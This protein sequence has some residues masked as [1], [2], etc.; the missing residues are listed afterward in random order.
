YLRCGN[1][2]SMFFRRALF[3]EIG[4]FDV[5]L[6]VGSSTGLHSGEEADML[7]RALDAGFAPHYTPDLCV[8]HDQVDAMIGEAEVGR[9]G[10]YGRGFGALM[11]KHRFSVLEV[12]YR[13]GRSLVAAALYLLRGRSMAARYKWEWAKGILAGYRN[14]P[15]LEP[16]LLPP[17]GA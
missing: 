13:I 1:S 6:G 7:L 2:N 17:Q 14:W 12:A 3:A 11:R 4:R 5:R 16:R 15:Q 8:H 10:R 9:A